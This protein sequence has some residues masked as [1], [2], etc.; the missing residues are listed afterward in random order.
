MSDQYILDDDGRPVRCD[1]LL[2][3][4]RWYETADR[5]VCQDLDEGEG[6]E[7]ILVSTIFLGIDHNYFGTGPPL[8]WE[9]MVF[10][11]PLDGEQHRYHSQAEAALGH[12]EVCQRVKLALEIDRLG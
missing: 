6:A 3:W 12:Q 8:L 7:R 4:A 10:G 2:T 1:D 11:G 5:R 9:T